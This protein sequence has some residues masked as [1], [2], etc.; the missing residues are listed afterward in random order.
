M[1]DSDWELLSGS[2]RQQVKMGC[3]G[4]PRTDDIR[5]GQTAFGLPTFISRHN[6]E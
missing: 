2:R 5:P 1:A 4:V 6:L 3:K